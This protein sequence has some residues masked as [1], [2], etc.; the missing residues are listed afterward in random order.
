MYAN[1]KGQWVLL[2]QGS[3]LKDIIWWYSWL[4]DPVVADCIE[5]FPDS[6]AYLSDITSEFQMHLWCG[7]GVGMVGVDNF[8]IFS[9]AISPFGGECS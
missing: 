4:G 5:N 9:T 2:V 3:Q 6:L 1:N 8:N 7:M